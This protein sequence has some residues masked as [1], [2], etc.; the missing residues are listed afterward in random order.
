[1][2]Y[3]LGYYIVG[4]VLRVLYRIKIVGRGKLPP[5]AGVLCGNHTSMFD[6][7]VAALAL[8]LK[9]K[10]A[11]MAKKELFKSKFLSGL[12]RHLGAFPVDREKADLT[13]IKTALGV[14]KNGKKLLVFPSG[15]RIKPDEAV[16]S[17]NGAGMLA[18]RAGVPLI[19]MY[20]SRGRKVIINRIRIEFGEPYYFAEG[21]VSPEEYG[22]AV[23]SVMEAVAAMEIKR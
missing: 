17:K 6:P 5:G 14:L 10:P 19:P 8:G 7:I 18:S 11:F 22:K 21:K 4:S 12:I 1:M 16:A 3:F 23:E 13:A 20:I 9:D 2:L 15:T